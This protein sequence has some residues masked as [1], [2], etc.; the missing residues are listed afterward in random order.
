MA[1][2]EFGARLDRNGYAPSLLCGR[3][4]YRCGLGASAFEP[5]LA[6]HELFGG[7][8]RAKSKALGLWV[9][10]C[11]TCHRIAHDDAR[12]AEQWHIEGQRAAMEAYNWSTGEFISRFGRNYME[13]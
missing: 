7:P 2:N 6:R 12:T 3:C 4:C 1:R 9:Y 8:N 5:N 13:D 11:P 10:V